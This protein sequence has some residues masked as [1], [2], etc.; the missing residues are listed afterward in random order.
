MGLLTM[1][2]HTE[3]GTTGSSAW[4][5]RTA[6][7]PNTLL[8]PRQPRWSRWRY[9]RRGGGRPGTRLPIPAV[10]ALRTARPLRGH[11]RSARRGRG[12]DRRV[13]GHAVQ[14]ARSR[15]AH[16]IATGRGDADEARRL[17]SGEVF[18]SL[19]VDVI[20]ALHAH[21]PDGVDA[22]LDLVN[23]RSHPQ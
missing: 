12:R 16:V 18:D 7:T 22:V 5:G 2:D 4:R 23:G 6:P 17:G 15:G 10:T 21:H 20:D 8:S 3:A 19:T 13:G 9:P 11:R 1:S 14:I